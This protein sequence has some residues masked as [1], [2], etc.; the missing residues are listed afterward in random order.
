MFEAVLARE[1]SLDGFT[2]DWSDGPPAPGEPG[3]AE[4]QSYLAYEQQQIAFWN[5]YAAGDAPP[6]GRLPNLNG[7]RSDESLLHEI[8]RQ[9]RRENAAAGAKLRAVADYAFRQMANPAVGY[10][11]AHMKR[12]VEAEVAGM[13]R[14]P[15]SA[16]SETV[17]LALMLARRLPKTFDALERGVLTRFA[18]R[19]IADESANLNVAQCARLEDEVLS[20]A[21]R[22]SYRS[23]R[24][25][26]R[27]EVE[28]LDADAVR[29]R[30]EKAR[31]ERTLYVKDEHDGMATLCLTVPAEV[32]HAI[33]DAINDR[34]L[35]AQATA[36]RDAADAALVLAPRD[37]RRVGAQRADTT[38]DILAAGLS[39]DPW[40]PPVP[41]SSFLTE[42]QIAAL[43]RGAGTY[44]PSKAMKAAVR[45]R[46]K[47]C[48]FP[49]CRRPAR[50]CDLDSEDGA[51]HL[52]APV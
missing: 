49:G 33:Y 10:D 38:V 22:R 11:Q 18:A 23:L 12:S 24:K 42:E 15:P 45:S 51:R 30:A 31:E 43:D 40:A 4:Y 17:G 3:Y 9:A 25:K 29:K 48:R 39:I 13:L 32:A 5:A 50:L 34:V 6:E 47:H 36:K 37:D 41:A 26:V 44:V 16:A 21:E 52:L 14:L 27:R 1:L 8:E 7:A 28:K 20:D 2:P 19:L 46:D 35:S